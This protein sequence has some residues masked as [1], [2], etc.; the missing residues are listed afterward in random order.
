MIRVALALAL[1]CAA[2]FA[3]GETYT[4]ERARGFLNQYCKACHTGKNAV[5]GF[6][7][8]AVAERESLAGETRK[9]TSLVRRVHDGEMPPKN[10]PAPEL[11]ERVAFTDWAGQALREQVC[12]AGVAPGPSPLRRLNRDEYTATIQDLFELHVDLSGLLPAEGAGGE[13][14][15]N[16]AETLFLSP[17]HSEKYMEAAKLAVEFAAREYK[18]R[19][20]IL[21]AKPGAGVTP[22]QA[23][24]RIL[25]AL[26]PRAFRRPVS[27][28]EVTPYVELYRAA[29]REGMDHE[30]AVF[31]AIRGV[32]VS[33]NFLYRYEPP[34]LTGKDRALDSYS[35]A[36]RISYFL[37]GSM[38]DEFLFDIAARGKLHDA[39]VIRQVV[40]RMLRHDRAEVFA[41]RFIEQW[42]HTRDLSGD[43]APDAKLFPEWAGDEELRGDIRLQPVY[44][45]R[46]MFARNLPVL[47]LLDST[48][49]IGTSN[50]EKLWNVKLP[51]NPNQ[52][53]QPHWVELPAG[54][55]RGGLLGMP[56]V[57]AV[58]SYPYRTSPVLRGA[59][60]LETILGTPPPP[61]P[62][63]VPA[64]EE[65]HEG[66]APK[67]LRERLEQHRANPVCASCHSRIDGLG[68]ALENY[69]VIGRW[70]TH[71]AGKPLDT[72]GELADGTRF[73]GPEGLRKVLVDRKELFLRNF[74]SKMLG[75]ALGRGLTVR[76]SCTVDQ[77]VET[78]KRKDY[79]IQTLIEEIVLS[80]PFRYQ[81]PAAVAPAA[82]GKEKP[83]S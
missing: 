33:P 5:G 47:T 69:D 45:L 64:L 48:H 67:S 8:E 34:N 66:A 12:A 28:A 74:T 38:P 25:A 76:D 78:L 80:V 21:V 82:V 75:Y 59:W 23:A 49:T 32:L 53:K 81:A 1:V 15:D 37:W 27:G 68:F 10:A 57:H 35:L 56:A 19:E 58:S 72:T 55:N 54:S 17:L 13:G 20:R 65:V 6:R 43:K 31:F 77:I 52:R 50:L 83:K 9:W 2:G 42:L 51:L 71:E 46:E 4:F 63:D 44:F 62:P 60:I 22:E 73:E 70:R 14:F 7:V 39:E 36:S 26:L 3:Q 30:P 11:N 16:A 61:P 24:R 79:R 41:R 29:R 18:S 40:P